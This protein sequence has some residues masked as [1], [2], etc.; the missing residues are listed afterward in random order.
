MQIAFSQLDCHKNYIIA[1]NEVK[2]SEALMQ[3]A[4]IVLLIQECYFYSNA[5]SEQ[6]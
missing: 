6:R 3:L 2:S 4:C 5:L 1:I